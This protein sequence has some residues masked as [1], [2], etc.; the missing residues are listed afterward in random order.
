MIGSWDDCLVVWWENLGAA[1]SWKTHF[2]DDIEEP[3]ATLL[4]DFDGDGD[5]DILAASREDEGVFWF[6]N[7]WS[8]PGIEFPDPGSF[9]KVYDPPLQSGPIATADIDGDGDMDL[10]TT[11]RGDDDVDWEENVNGDGSVW[12]NHSISGD[13]DLPQDVIGSDIDCDGD[14][15]VLALGF[16][17]VSIWKNSDGAGD[18]ADPLLVE[19][20]FEGAQSMAVG[21][22]DRDG[23]QD[24]IVAV[25]NSHGFLF[26]IENADG[27]GT[28]WE[29]IEIFPSGATQ[30]A[31]ISLADLDGDGDL[32]VLSTSDGNRALV[33][34]EN[35]GNGGTWTAH[36]VDTNPQQPT[37]AAAA[38]ADGDGD[39]DI[40]ATHEFGVSW[41]E[42][43]GTDTWQEHPILSDLG[44]AQI[45]RPHDFDRDGDV[46][47]VIYNSQGKRVHFIE[48]LNKGQEWKTEVLPTPNTSPLKEA[49]GL[50]LADLT[51]DGLIDICISGTLEQANE[52][53]LA[54]W[55]PTWKE[56]PQSLPLA[57]TSI[58]QIGTDEA[59]NAL[60]EISWNAEPGCDY[61]IEIS[62]D[63]QIWALFGFPSDSI[64]AGATTASKIVTPPTG[65]QRVYYRVISQ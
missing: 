53:I 44:T 3:T 18:F 54:H 57:I 25:T 6:P 28:S 14:I 52:L 7:V 65:K 23:D 13:R 41:W 27:K 24:M 35:D 2:V 20:T 36:V 63:L 51:G 33:W 40:F 61:Q 56:H 37:N 47:V 16:A 9:Q 48:N 1:V 30:L 4:G 21:D 31:E 38:D 22:L 17:E 64:R 34:S 60:L 50:E 26:Y 39:L 45:V 5:L 43:S 55:S 29:P 11:N 12:I 19:F 49:L 10:I 46:D 59:D 8:S 58:R 32:D 15:D 62:T 42:N